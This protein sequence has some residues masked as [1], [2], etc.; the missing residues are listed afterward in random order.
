LVE[1]YQRLTRPE[2][3]QAP[4]WAAKIHVA[5]YPVYYQN[6]ELGFLVAAQ[7]Q[8]CLRQQAGGIVNRKAAGQWLIEKFFRPGAQEDWASHVQTST[9]ELLNPEYFVASAADRFA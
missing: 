7:L 8:N 5:L 1:R 4:D 3:R 6:Y 2:N 9:G